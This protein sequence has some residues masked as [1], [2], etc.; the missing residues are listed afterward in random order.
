MIKKITFTDVL[1]APNWPEMKVEYEKEG[2]TEGF[3]PCVP[4]LEVYKKL[5][6]IGVLHVFGAYLRE[7]LIGFISVLHTPASHYE[8]PLCVS[9]SFFVFKEHRHT[10]AG[11]K[12]LREAE[13]FAGNHS[14]G[15]LVSAPYGGT[16]A[17]VLEKKEDY[18]QTSQVFFKRCV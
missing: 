13:N 10:G 12:L 2:H 16:L 6:G 17:A 3:P 5:E 11:L 4:N 8:I 1:S 15:L 7:K 18:R 9:E 14:A